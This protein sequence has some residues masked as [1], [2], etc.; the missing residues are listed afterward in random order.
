M[1]FICRKC[2]DEGTSDKP[3][4]FIVK[5]AKQMKYE[6]DDWEQALRRCPF[7][8]TT[9]QIGTPRWRLTGESPL[10]EWERK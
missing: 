6:R 1:K 4:I 2:I 9:G 5:G 10:A 7:E 8:T 3:C